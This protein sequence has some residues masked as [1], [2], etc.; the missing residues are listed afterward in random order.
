MRDFA[1]GR[2]GP[3]LRVLAPM[4]CHRTRHIVLLALLTTVTTFA[5]ACG[6]DK[7]PG[8]TAGNTATVTATATA[9]TPGMTGTPATDSMSAT[10]ESTGGTD[11]G[12]MTGSSTGA[13][14][15][16]D[17]TTNDP[18]GGG[19]GVNLC[20]ETCQSD[21]DCH[22]AGEPVGYA[23]KQGLCTA[24]VP[25]GNCG[26]DFDC[27]VLLSGWAT[28]CASQAEC[29]NQFCIDIGGGVGRCAFGPNDV[30]DCATLQQVEIQMPPIEGGPDITVCSNLDWACIDSYCQNPCKVDADC[31]L[32]PGL[33]R[34]NAATGRCECS[35]DADCASSGTP[36]FTAC[37]TTF[38]GCAGDDACTTANTDTCYD[39][40]CGC[41]SS[42]VCT[43]K[44]FD[45]TQIA[46][47]SL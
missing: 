9:T 1:H 26:D 11:S 2:E 12:S 14:T 41:S 23:C 3:D 36:G 44:A 8:N 25:S 43:S 20:R 28:P 35:S 31:A 5:P 6:D 19:P 33:P 40:I 18:T 22:I 29:P 16:D 4:G 15:T 13:P 37:K 45:G 32:Y 21:A 17:P 27:Q 46:C 24:D 34:C 7:E 47:E 30:I 38:C 10:G 42:A 39:G